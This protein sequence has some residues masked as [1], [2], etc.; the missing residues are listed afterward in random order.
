[1]ITIDLI[2][3]KEL[4]AKFNDMPQK[5]F[6]GVARALMRIQLDMITA[7]V[8]KL[9][10]PVVKRV[11]DTLASSIN[12]R[13]G[14][15]RFEQTAST[16]TATIGTNVKYAAPIEY[17]SR[18]HTILPKNARAL[19]FEWKGARVFFRKV[20]HPGTPPRSFLRSTLRDFDSRIRTDIEA[21]TQEAVR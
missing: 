17:G 19:A 6:S 4:I 3:D 9:S 20:E 2:G 14:V 8:G 21:A 10:G 16:I 12:F 18:P 15:T 13:G 11:T 7:V 5:V 1:M